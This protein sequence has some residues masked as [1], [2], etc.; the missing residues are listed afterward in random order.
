MACI[1]ALNPYIH[2]YLMKTTIELPDELL[3][4]AKSVAA[5]RRTTLK[6]MI[7]HAL[8]RELLLTSSPSAA[9]AI[10]EENEHGFP[11]LKR[12]GEGTITSEMVYALLDEE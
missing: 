4:R 3:T 11:V 1:N 2:P 9:D 7:E 8:R 12:D 10:W 6:S 5:Q